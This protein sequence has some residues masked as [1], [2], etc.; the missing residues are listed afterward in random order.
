MEA[1]VV[2]MH[3]YEADTRIW[4]ICDNVIP[5]HW[6][7]TNVNMKASEADNIVRTANLKALCGKATAE[8]LIHQDH[9]FS[10]SY[11]LELIHRHAAGLPFRRR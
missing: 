8:A 7:K 10:T 11:V 5:N 9:D 6:K 1:I 2:Q 4:R 3:Q